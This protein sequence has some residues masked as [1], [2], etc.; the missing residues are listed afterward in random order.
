LAVAMVPKPDAIEPDDK[1]PTVVSD[2]VTTLADSAVPVRPFAGTAAAVIEVLQPKPV[3]V[4][5]ISASAAAEQL[6]TT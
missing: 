6:E 1:A 5:Q 2:D 4:V 3:L